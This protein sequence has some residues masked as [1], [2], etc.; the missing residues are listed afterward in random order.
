MRRADR[1]APY[2]FAA[3]AA[4]YLLVFTAWPLLDGV[5]LSFTDTR[6]LNPAGGEWIGTDNYTALFEDARFAGT[7]GVTLIY[8]LATVAGALLIGTAGAVLLDRAFRGRTALRALLTLPWAAPTVAVALIFV[9]MFNTDDGV[10]NHVTEAAGLGRHGWLTAYALA[11]VTAVSIW[12]VFPFVMLVALAA[13]QSVP[14]ELVEAAVVDGAGPATVFRSVTWP[15][16]V[17]TLRVVALLMT[18]WSFRRFEIIWL[19]TQGGPVDRTTTL[20]IDVYRTAFLESDLGRSAAT[21]TVGLGL[22]AI[23]T[24][25]YALVERRSARKDLA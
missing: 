4:L 12:K 23:A 1:F 14:K 17:P 22:S 15:F 7:L 2:V 6:L 21:G 13:L 18:I 24:V 5:W 19:L 10:F 3:A 20:V 25:V 8:S 9:W 16:L 11:T